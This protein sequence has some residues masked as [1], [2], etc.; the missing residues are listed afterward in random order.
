MSLLVLLLLQDFS[1]ADDPVFK[2]NVGAFGR[3]SL[4]IGAVESV[5]ITNAG[6]VI[7][8][9]D[10]LRYSDLFDPGVG[11][12]LEFDVAF[13]PEPVRPGRSLHSQ[14]PAFGA[15]AALHLDRFGGRE[16]DDEAGTRIEPDDLRIVSGLVG[17][18][19]AGT[20]HGRHFGELKAGAGLAFYDAVGAR[21]TGPSGIS[22]AGELFDDSRAFLAELRLRY[23]YRVGPAAF[24]LGFGLRVNLGPDAGAGASSGVEPGPLWLLDFELGLQLGL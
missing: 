24:L 3:A 5:D 22:T 8:L 18:K 2:V 13:R 23:G 15:Y 1:V 11:G 19:V 21:F 16:E 4:P 9:G 17:A 6:E 7:F 12:S 10:K 14:S 20:V